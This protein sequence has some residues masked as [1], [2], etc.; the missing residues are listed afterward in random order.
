ME[1][2]CPRSCLVCGKSVK[3]QNA[4]TIYPRGGGRGEGKGAPIQ[5]RVGAPRAFQGLKA[6]LVPLAA[7]K[8]QHR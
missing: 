1:I 6:G 2:N 5:K 8:G 4:C 7:T 3:T